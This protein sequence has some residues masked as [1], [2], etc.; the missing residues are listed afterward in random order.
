MCA[1]R[2]EGRAHRYL[3]LVEKEEAQESAVRRMTRKL[4]GDSPELVMAHLLNE[5]GLTEKQLRRLRALVDERL[6]EEGEM[7]AAWMFYALL[8]GCWLAAGPWLWK[9]SS[10]PTVCRLVGFGPAPWGSPFS[11]LWSISFPRRPAETV[12]PASLPEPS[13]VVAMEP[14]TV[15]VGPESALRGF[16]EPILLLWLSSSVLLLTLALLILFRTYRLRRE[17]TGDCAGGKSVLLSEEWGPAVVGFLRPQIVLPRWCRDMDEENLSLILDHEAEHLRAGD[18]RLLLLAGILPI[19]FPWNLPIWWQLGRLRIAVEG[20]CDLRVLRKYPNQTRSY[21][22]LLL[23]VGGRVPRRQV[24]ATMLSEPGE[25]LERRIRIMTTPSPKNPWPRGVLLAGLGVVFV[26]LA[27]S[28]PSPD[29]VEEADP[30]YE[31]ELPPERPVGRAGGGLDLSGTR[32]HAFHRPPR[33][34]ETGGCGRSFW[35]P[36]TPGVQGPGNRRHRPGLGLHRRGGEVQ[37][38]QVDKSSGHESLDQAAVRVAQ[39][40]RIHARP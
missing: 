32:L 24:A 38:V 9:G 28:A 23:E 13:W 8:V 10:G 40:D 16:D 39:E 20:D 29:N 6:K 21:L 26:A 33:D 19:L 11:G 31:I 7:I 5:K 17:W 25:T 1:M 34:R 12:V 4:F 30:G 37:K 22:E 14:L 27:C 36:N 3:P 2:A 18:L 35:K 15:Q